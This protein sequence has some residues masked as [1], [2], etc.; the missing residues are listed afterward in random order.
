M[1][2]VKRNGKTEPVR[3][4]LITERLASLVEDLDIDPIIITQKV[5][6]RLKNLMT[7]KELDDLA[8]QICMNLSESDPKYQILAARIAIDNHQRCTTGNFA[9]TMKILYENR[10]INGN[11]S[12]LISEQVYRISQEYASKTY[13]ERDCFQDMIDYTRDFYFDYFGFHN[14]LL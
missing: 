5:S 10:D 4:D 6:S 11:H 1:Q 14:N 12:P 9:Q 2:V 8:A 13:P 7:T 3:F